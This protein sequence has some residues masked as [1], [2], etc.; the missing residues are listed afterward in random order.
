M[1]KNTNRFYILE[2]NT[3]PGMTPT[4]LV[5]EIAKYKGTEFDELI[6]W[7]L[8]DDERNK[9]LSSKARLKAKK[10]WDSK[11]I[12]KKYIDAYHSALNNY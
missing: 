2:L 1:E 3:Q 9:K 6:N 8:E 4:S 7:I 12:A 11:I 10:Y 5:P